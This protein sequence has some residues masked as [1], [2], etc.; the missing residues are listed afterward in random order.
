MARGSGFNGDTEVV[1]RSIGRALD[2]MEIVVGDRGCN[3]TSAASDAGLTPTTALRYLRALDARGYLV[4]DETGLYSAGPTLLR[5]A[6]AL[7]EYGPLDR[8]VAVAQPHLNSLA[9]NTGESAYLAI[10]DKGT[11][12]YVATAESDRAIRHVGWVG[13]NVPLQGSAVGDALASP[14]VASVRTGAV[15]PDTTAISLALAD[16]GKLRLALSVVGPEHRLNKK[17][18]DHVKRILTQTAA[19][20]SRDL[21]LDQEVKSK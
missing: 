7:H 8:L 16:S 5:M 9:A 20:L 13:Q 12:T 2:L 18:T 17:T 10:G 1:P 15:E 21:G 19:E 6:A 11:A 4:R 3:L 14:G